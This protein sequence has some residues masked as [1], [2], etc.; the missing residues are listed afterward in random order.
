MVIIYRE[1]FFSDSEI[2]PHQLGRVHGGLAVA[3]VLM[4]WMGVLLRYS[5]RSV[6]RV[7]FPERF[8]SSVIFSELMNP[9]LT[10]KASDRAI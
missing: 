3:M 9:V 10:R 7:R 5:F 6:A 4:A 1:F 2:R 8:K